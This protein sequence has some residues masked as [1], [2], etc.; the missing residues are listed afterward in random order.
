MSILKDFT[1][2]ENLTGLDISSEMLEISA[3]F[4]RNLKL[5]SVYNLPFDDNS[6]DL[7]TCSSALHHLDNL[8]KAISEIYRVLSPGGIF[9]SDCDNNVHFAK[10]HNLK[11]KLFKA[12]LVYPIFIKL[13]KKTNKSSSKGLKEK[14]LEELSLEELHKIS[15]AQNYHQ[16]GVNGVLLRNFLLGAG[17]KKTE[18]FVYNSHK[19]NKGVFFNPWNNIFNNK[20]YSISTKQEV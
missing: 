12:L 10:I 2:E 6:F 15:E 3:K 5:G 11:R 17:F 9:I 4:C 18:I 16:G 20:L 7:V 8:E 19:W 13:F 1:E 14:N